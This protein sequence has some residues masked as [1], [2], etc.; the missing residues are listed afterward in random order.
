MRDPDTKELIVA[1]LA[2]LAELPVSMQQENRE[3][4][5]YLTRELFACPDMTEKDIARGMQG[6]MF[7]PEMFAIPFLELNKRLGKLEGL[8]LS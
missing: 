3:Q 7:F 4:I 2:I 6:L 5:L 8:A 1:Q